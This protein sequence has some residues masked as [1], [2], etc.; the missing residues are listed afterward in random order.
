MAH[1]LKHG[2][3]G[4]ELTQAEWEA[5]G[6]HVLD[7]QATGDIIYASSSSQ[8]RRLAKGTD[9]HVLILSSGIPA[10]SASTG[11][12]SVGTLTDLTV[13]GTSTTIGTVTSGVWQGTDVGV[14]YGGTG[15]STLTANGVLVGN[16][17]SAITSVDM[18]TKGHVLIGDGS[19]NPQ[20]L[21]V[22][23]NNHVLT[24][25]SGETTGVK[26]AAPAAAAAGSLTGSTLA[27][28]VTASSLT[29][30]GT[31]TGLTMSGSVDLGSQTLL[32]LGNSGND[33]TANTW[34]MNNANS[35]GQNTIQVSNSSN[36]TSSEARFNA[37]VAGASANDAY[38]RAAR[39]GGGAKMRIGI[40]TSEGLIVWTRGDPMGTDDIMRATDASPPVV[41]YNTSHPTGTFD[42]V[43]GQC[44]RHEAEIFTCCGSVEWH[45]DVMD[46]R[47]MALRDPD[48]LDYMERVGVIEQTRSNEGEP[49]IFTVL[50][51]DFEFAMSASFQNRQ[52]MDA[53]HKAMNER[54]VR[55]EQA[56]G[57]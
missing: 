24:A 18:S 6:A 7:S 4:T 1:E 43:C 38:F 14:A 22:G 11:I 45:D 28:G 2:T 26:W 8:L 3:V 9:T 25:D 51:K 46:F 57:V 42:Y 53:Q 32:N 31:L 49:E 13:S 44:G 55:I 35:G 17:G 33:L 30:V 41:S 15:V 27:S 56:L 37:T 40:D 12:T 47:A 48:A 23:T 50:G 36:T 34:Q 54:L 29:S 5:V 10:W 16:G 21:A 20:M 52:R 19:G 39:D